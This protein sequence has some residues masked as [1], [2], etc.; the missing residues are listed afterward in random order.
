MPEPLTIE[1]CREY[2]AVEILKWKLGHIVP[3]DDDTELVYTA[4]YHDDIDGGFVFPTKEGWKPDID[5]NQLVLVLNGIKALDDVDG[6]KVLDEAAGLSPRDEYDVQNFV[7]KGFYQKCTYDPAE[8]LQAIC[9]AH[10][11]HNA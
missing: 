6:Y 11:G 10:R 5:R 4:G 1:A 8:A 2:S 7:L 3:S 9:E